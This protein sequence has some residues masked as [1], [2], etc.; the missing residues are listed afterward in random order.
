MNIE[1]I[2]HELTML[3]RDVCDRH[4]LDIR[5]LQEKVEAQERRISDLESDLR[6][7]QNN[8]QYMERS[9]AS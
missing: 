7:A 3:K 2:E 6:T 5:R 8:I 1:D 9:A 4:A